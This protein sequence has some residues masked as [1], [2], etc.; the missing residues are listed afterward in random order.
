MVADVRRADRLPTR[1]LP[2]KQKSKNPDAGFL[3]QCRRGPAS[4]EGIRKLC[5]PAQSWRTVPARKGS[6]VSAS[7]AQGTA[8]RIAAFGERRRKHVPLGVRV[9]DSRRIRCRGGADPQQ[10]A[11]FCIAAL[12]A[13]RCGKRARQAWLIPRVKRIFGLLLNWGTV[14]RMSRDGPDALWLHRSGARITVGMGRSGFDRRSRPG[15]GKRYRQLHRRP[16]AA[17][18]IEKLQK[19]QLLAG[20][21]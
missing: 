3:F 14:K 10:G 4:R 20:R 19:A 6:G 13:G 21:C 15:S 9:S 5:K 16:H 2:T 1:K 17:P 7:R 11:P 8:I 18:D 12:R